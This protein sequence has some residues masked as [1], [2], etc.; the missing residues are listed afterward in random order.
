M[1]QKRITK[2]NLKTTLVPVLPNT[3][4]RD[5]LWNSAYVLSSLK[6]DWFFI[7]FKYCAATIHSNWKGHLE[8]PDLKI[9]S[10]H[11]LIRAILDLPWFCKHLR[12][13]L[14]TARRRQLL[15]QSVRFPCRGRRAHRNCLSLFCVDASSSLAFRRGK[16]T[17]GSPYE[18]I[19]NMNWL[20]APAV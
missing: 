14:L 19:F 12:D 16:A 10:D 18:T 17:E 13:P 6:Q 11:F 20:K 15:R 8:E 4:P 2:N 7:Y 1:K 9:N 3:K 5:L